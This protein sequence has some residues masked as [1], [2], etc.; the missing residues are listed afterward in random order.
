MLSF[1]EM[2]RKF[3]AIAAYYCLLEIEKAARHRS[4]EV[5]DGMDLETRLQNACRAQ[6]EMRNPNQ[7]A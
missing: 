6:D 4:S 3:G 5:A 7:V 1:Q 2:E